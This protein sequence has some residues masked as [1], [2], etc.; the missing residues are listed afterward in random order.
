MCLVEGVIGAFVNWG[1]YCAL[2]K[3][4]PR[5]LILYKCSLPFL[6]SKIPT[7][8]NHERKKWHQSQNL[9]ITMKYPMGRN[10]FILYNKIL[11][12][13][14]DISN[15]SINFCRWRAIWLLD[16]CIIKF[17]GKI[18][19]LTNQEQNLIKKSC[20]KYLLVCL[21]MWASQKGSLGSKCI[22]HGWPEPLPAI[23]HFGASSYWPRQDFED[24]VIHSICF[25]LN[26]YIIIKLAPQFS[27]RDATGVASCNYSVLYNK[28][29][30][31]LD[32][33]YNFYSLFEIKWKDIISAFLPFNYFMSQWVH[34]QI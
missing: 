14:L 12:I 13:M 6:F 21:R 5:G 11:F 4:E 1:I 32:G 15:D 22:R 7:L 10:V 9:N 18:Q 28:Q 25:C 16:H 34:C 30:N 23:S 31:I 3:H 20:L 8:N 19:F 29:K 33:G 2:L 24:L 26:K 17:K 27:C